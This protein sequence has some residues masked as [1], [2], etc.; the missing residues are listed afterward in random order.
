MRRPR[1][2][3]LLLG[4][5]LSDT[6]R[7][8]TKYAAVVAIVASSGS[9]FQSSSI[10]AAALLPAAL[11]GLY[12]GGL[13]DS[14]PKGVALGAAYGLSGLTSILI[15]IVF[16]T[17]LVP[18]LALVFVVAAFSQLAIPAENVTVPLLTKEG[19]MASAN[20]MMGMSSSLG[21]AVGTA[22]VAP[23]L[24]KV[25]GVQFVFYFAGVLMLVGATRVLHIRSRR[26]TSD[27]ATGLL[28][29]RGENLKVLRW[30]F[31]HQS[32]GTM[33]AVSVLVTVSNLI[34]TAL[35]PVYV[36]E[37][38]KT[39]P[40]NA[41]FVMGPSGIAMVLSIAIAPF[42]IRL[43]GERVT[44]AIGVGFV[45][46]AL[47]ALGLV[48]NDLAL[49]VDPANPLRVVGLVGLDLTAELRTAMLL[50]IPLGLG[51]GLTD[52][53]VKT[54]INRRVPLDYQGRT[55]AARS[56]L[57]S[58]VAIVPL[59]AVAGVASLVGV[60]PVL[61]ALPLVIYAVLLIL[62]QLSRRYGVEVIGPMTMVAQML[63]NETEEELEEPAPATPNG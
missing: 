43:V 25:L 50:S 4:K 27:A 10:A 42:V 62:L 8:A 26:D 47:V 28:P 37:V 18:M 58:I 32:I 7:D 53:A 57:E 33:V 12:A 19:E 30:I 24:L 15:P 2:Q 56:T 34:M 44:T 1:F 16:G 35:A 46:V 14:L 3:H 39:D 61:I 6:A 55:F 31:A 17:E 22:L 40:A 60:S 51:A 54:Y 48:D 49:V 45:V 11:F 23:I 41:V 9:A 5:L 52:N 20:S 36:H 29:E 13:A 63:T 38:L 21:T 59:M